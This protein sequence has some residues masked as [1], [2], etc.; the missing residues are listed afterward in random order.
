MENLKLY[1]ISERYDALSA[2]NPGLLAKL[3][4]LLLLLFLLL[5]WLLLLLLLLLLLFTKMTRFP[6]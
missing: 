5:S 4:L 3:F 6:T 2:S 1:F